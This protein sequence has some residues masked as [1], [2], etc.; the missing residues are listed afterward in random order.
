MSRYLIFQDVNSLILLQKTVQY[1]INHAQT[2]E[3]DKEADPPTL[4]KRKLD[5]FDQKQGE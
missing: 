4:D 5:H 3:K 1:T 2:G